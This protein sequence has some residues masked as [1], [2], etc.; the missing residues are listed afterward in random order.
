M[1]VLSTGK[2]IS[3][4]PSDVVQTFGRSV[5]Q[6]GR[7]NDRAYLMKLDSLDMPRIIETLD[8]L[9][10]RHGYSKIF[11]KV[12]RSQLPAFERAGYRLEALVPG[13]FAGLED[14]AFLGKYMTEERK[15]D[16]ARPTILANLEAARSRA[17]VRAPAL[18]GKGPRIRLA[19]E[20]DVDAMAHLFRT[21]FTTYPFPIQDPEYLRETMETHVRYFCIEHDGEIIAASSAEM[22]RSSRC[23]E[24]TDFATLPQQRG[25]RLA[26]HLLAFMER[27]PAIAMYRNAYTIAR[28]LSVGVNVTFAR[29]GYTFAGILTQNTNISG[30]IESMNVWYKPLSASPVLGSAV[31]GASC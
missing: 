3:M 19:S 29:L 24:M 21:V 2:Q 14:G 8:G 6:H 5:V 16:P 30:Q 11:A 25:R 7:C 28:A 10:A 1:A 9:A 26:A 12:P 20:R 23:V 15:T 17:A 4:T 27:D 31:A 13:F 18:D 22:D